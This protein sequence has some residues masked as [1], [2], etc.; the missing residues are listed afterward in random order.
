MSVRTCV[1]EIS[2]GVEPK[3]TME[4]TCDV[5]SCGEKRRGLK[6]LE[7]G[8]ILVQSTELGFMPAGKRHFCSPGCLRH[9]TVLVDG[10][11]DDAVLPVVEPLEEE[12]APRKLRTVGE[13]LA[14]TDPN[15][16]PEESAEE[17]TTLYPDGDA[18]G[19]IVSA[20]DY[21]P[22]RSSVEG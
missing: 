2:A 1:E 20:R 22:R 18:P 13:W 3:G 8:M 21:R 14:E 19:R 10:G 12:P 16:R 11:K 5:R 6:P 4:Y 15:R 9:W 17:G 7:A